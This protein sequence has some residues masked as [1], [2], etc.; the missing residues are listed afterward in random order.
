MVVYPLLT[1][2]LHLSN[3][4]TGLHEIL[5]TFQPITLGEMK[6][7]ELMDRDDTKFVV[8][9]EAIL[10]ILPGLVADYRVLEV[11]GN[12]ASTYETVY[13][14]T[15]DFFFYTRHHNG[16][17]NRMKIRKRRYVESNL[18]F[19]EVKFKTNREKTLKDR[20]RLP[21]IRDDLNTSELHFIDEE[22]H[23]GRELEPKIW[24]FFTRVTL[25]SQVLRE[26][27]TIDFSLS[28]RNASGERYTLRR[29]AIVEVKQPRRSRLSP[30]MAALHKRHI[31]PESMSKYC[32]GVANLY[33]NVKK[34][35]FKPKLR[36]IASL[37]TYDQRH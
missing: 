7:V 16:K 26:R 33:P 32:L 29:L 4:V 12:R 28:F 1:L 20:T 19:L 17:M 14:D 37:E 25:V 31:R 27:I 9:V 22:T 10:E 11:E 8:P 34:N 5:E 3:S 35:A 30:M 2:A 6:G 23:F 24:N 21:E 15:P 36:R 18:N 13:Y